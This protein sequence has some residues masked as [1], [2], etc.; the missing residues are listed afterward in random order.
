MILAETGSTSDL[1]LLGFFGVFLALG[2][3]IRT[4][5]SRRAH[6]E[7]VRGAKTEEPDDPKTA[8]RVGARVDRFEI[9]LHEY[10][11]DVEARMETR[12]ARLDRLVVSADQEICR[13]QDL[14]EK[15]GKRPQN[16]PDIAIGGDASNSDTPVREPLTSWQRRMVWHLQEAGYTPREVAVLLDRPESEIVAALE[17][18]RQAQPRAAG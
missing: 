11:R 9:R 13:L 16:G 10:S 17:F 15:K 7:T 1:I 6:E 2:F 14:L 4:V 3:W 12:L 8:D 5:F 18:E